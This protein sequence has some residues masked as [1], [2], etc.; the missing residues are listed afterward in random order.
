MPSAPTP[1]EKERP[2][3]VA[4]C[5]W[6]LDLRLEMITAPAEGWRTHSG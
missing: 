4:I 6:A 3:L 1:A 2:D 5:P